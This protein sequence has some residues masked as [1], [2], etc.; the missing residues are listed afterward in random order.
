MS[1]LP[2]ETP[3]ASDAPKADASSSG[4]PEASDVAS[5]DQPTSG[6]GSEPAPGA[7]TSAA[8]PAP[9]KAQLD[10]EAKLEELAELDLSVKERAR[11][12]EKATAKYER[13]A[14]ADEH[15]TKGELRQALRTFLGDKY[16]PDLLVELAGDFA[17][18][19]LSV[20]EQVKRELDARKKAEEEAAQKKLDDEKK[21]DESL[22]AE[23]KGVFVGR[24]AELLRT[25]QAQYPYIVAF[26]A[27]PNV[28][29]KAMV[30]AIIDRWSE[31]NEEPAPTPV[32]VLEAIEARYRQGYERA[33]PPK[34]DPREL[35]L[36]ESIGRPPAG[37]P[38]SPMAPPAPQG[39]VGLSGAE[40][41]RRRLEDE[42]RARAARSRMSYT[43]G[44]A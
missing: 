43:N 22:Y 32:Q 4:K 8:K 30:E 44:R 39:N 28:D 29:H 42:D 27:D 7:A 24:V 10:F 36:E 5:S 21:A 20:E 25:N 31:A 23:Q 15:L 3:P 6:S 38:P 19:Q 37:A 41:A 12:V 13:T 34:K 9:S 33:H 2:N 35:S 18:E 26:D 1:L 16:T 40:E 11:E 17:P 14:K